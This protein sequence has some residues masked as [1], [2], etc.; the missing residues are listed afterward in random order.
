MNIGIVG[1]GLIGG[2]IA[3]AIKHNTS[4]T[5]LGYDIDKSAIYKAKLLEAIDLE[6][7]DERLGICDIVIVALYPKDTVTYIKNNYQKFKKDVLVMDCGGVKGYVCD[8]LMDF[9][10]EKDFLFIGAHPMAGIERSGFDNSIHSMFQNASIVI[11]PPKDINIE[12]LEFLK[13]FWG[14]LGFTNLEFTTA[15]HHDE[16]IAYT[17][18]LAHVVS[19]AYI[20]SPTAVNHSGFSAGSYKDMTRVARLNENMWTELFLENKDALVNEIDIMIKNLTDYSNA[21][22]EENY[23]VLFNLLK[24]GRERKMLADRKDLKE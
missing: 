17:S 2:S 12:T 11:V 10:K 18:Q 16:M 23:E 1:L 7:T 21:I 4:D 14:A 15:E 20:K 6:L 19:S 9:S 22:K 24:D 8:N 13:K 5:V 3:K